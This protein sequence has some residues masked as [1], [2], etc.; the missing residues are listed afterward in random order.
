MSTLSKADEA[1][2]KAQLQA[3]VAACTERGLY[4]SA[5]WCVCAQHHGD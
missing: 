4:H 2:L 5:K 3:A 1:Q